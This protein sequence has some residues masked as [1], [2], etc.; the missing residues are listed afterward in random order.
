MI[1]VGIVDRDELPLFGLRY[2]LES[3]ADFVVAFAS[4]GLVGL[5]DAPLD[6]LV[7]DLE[8]ID[9]LAELGRARGAAAPLRVIGL[10]A[11]RPL[12]DRFR[13]TRPDLAEVQLREDAARELVGAVRRVTTLRRMPSAGADLRTGV[14]CLSPREAEVLR[15]IADGF[16]HDQA[17]HR[18][19]ISRH[20][21]DTYVKRMKSKLGVS[22]KV[23]LV[24][25][26]IAGVGY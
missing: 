2:V 20:T 23:Q 8:L 9:E 24:R 22:S 25:A 26:A 12:A 11:D 1:S 14:A 10:A 5:R 19:G 18:I 3:Q 16:T 21:V 6:C 13:H 15:Y 4:N 17:A 7:L